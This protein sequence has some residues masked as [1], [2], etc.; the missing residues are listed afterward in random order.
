M[1]VNILNH[2]INTPRTLRLILMTTVLPAIK[3]LVT[4]AGY[5]VGRDYTASFTLS[6]NI[7]SL[8]TTNSHWKKEGQKSVKFCLTKSCLNVHFLWAEKA[9]LCA[10]C[11]L[12]IFSKTLYSSLVATASTQFSH[13]WEILCTKPPRMPEDEQM[14]DKVIVMTFNPP[15]R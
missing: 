5:L 11:E 13:S 12:F 1:C 4:W 15:S 6:K 10:I 8:E 9:S 3:S 14:V 2:L 7:K